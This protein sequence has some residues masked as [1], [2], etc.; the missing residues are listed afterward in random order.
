M[1]WKLSNP[2]TAGNL[3]E[4]FDEFGIPYEQLGFM[5]HPNFMKAEK[6]HP[7]LME[8]YALY[9]ESRAYDSAYLQD[10]QT[11]STVRLGR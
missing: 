3:M 10:A 9:V 8:A 6:T 1:P 11:E 5:D 4:M 2:N 7:R